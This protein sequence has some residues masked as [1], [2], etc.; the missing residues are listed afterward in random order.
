MARAG[1]FVWA[2]LSV[3][4]LA[5]NTSHGDALGVNWGTQASH[6]LQPSI[7]VRLL[8][9]NG[10]NKVKLFDADSWTVNALAGSGIEVMVGIPNKDLQR[11]NSYKKAKHWVE[12]NV[13]KHLYDGGVDIR[14]VAVGNEPFLTSYN[15]SFLNTTFPALSNI[16]KA[17]DEAG[18]GDKIKATI[19]LNADVYESATNKPSDGQFRKDIKDLMIKIVKLLH[20]KKSAFVVNIYPFLSLYQNPDFPLDFAFFNGGGKP[21]EDKGVQYTNV[22]DANH[23]TLVW[24]LRKA[25]VPDLKILVGEIGWPTDGDKNANLKLARRFY[26]GLLKKL[27]DGKGTPLRPGRLDVYLFGLIDENMKSVAPGSFERHWGIFFFDGKPKF[28]MDFSGKGLDK[29]L[30]P[31]KGVIYL[32]PKWCVLNRDAVKNMTQVGPFVNYACSNSDCTSLGYGSS[33]NNLDQNGNV[34][35]AFNMYFQMQNQDVEA[36]NFNGMGKITTKNA[37]TGTCLF[38]VQM[39]SAGE[40]LIGYGVSVTGFMGLVLFGLLW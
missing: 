16:Q 26:D 40:K 3:V 28:P 39:M 10:I 18:H 20:E 33:C 15:G 8:K 32:E 24:A 4:L 34:S 38:P 29:F 30:E 6:I 11:Y 31:A 37:S 2:F 27:A 12:K 13:T 9:D 36:C 23:D 17:L 21:T 19:P 22:F 7:V 35:Y 1:A 14:Y 25:G 5:F